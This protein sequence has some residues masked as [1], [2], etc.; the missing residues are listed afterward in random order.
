MSKWRG[1]S[2]GIS[3]KLWHWAFPN[4]LGC[5]VDLIVLAIIVVGALLL[6]GAMP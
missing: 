6:A 1:E 2:A 5:Y 4:R 3:E